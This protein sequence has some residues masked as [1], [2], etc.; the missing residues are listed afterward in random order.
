MFE[1]GAAPTRAVWWQFT[2][3]AWAGILPEL[4]RGI[5]VVSDVLF[6]AYA[7]ALFWLLAPVT[8]LAAV[9]LRR[10]AWGWAASHMIARLYA[11]LCATPLV[12][13]GLENL[14]PEAPCVLVSNHASYLDGIV[15]VA[16]LSGKLSS[17]GYFSFVAKRELLDSFAPRTYLQGI[18]TDFVERFESQ[19]SLEDMKQVA[20][21]LQAGHSPVFFP[22][23]TF[24]RIPGLLPFRMGAF[25]VAAEAGAPVVPVTIR[26][27][28]SMLRDGHWF[29]RRGIITVTI[30]K[31]IAPERKGWAAAI[32]L[33]NKARAEIAR[34]CGEPDLAPGAEEE[35]AEV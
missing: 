8:L 5:R 22:E 1:K 18:G 13:R 19:R 32:L 35:P 20:H 6:A 14:S 12:V 34:R 27:T 2:R 24:T 17:A 28:R 9:L 30:G 25:V 15:V 10:P 7:W 23:G 31:P 21:S 26:G 29:P 4:R 11:R 3:L 33:R 16:A